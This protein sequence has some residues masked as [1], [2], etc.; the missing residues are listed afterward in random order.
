MGIFA[1]ILETAGSQTIFATDTVVSLFTGKSDPIVVS[2]AAASHFGIVP[3]VPSYPGVLA[4][5]SRFASTGQPLNFTVTALDPYGNVAP[6]YAGT[7][8]FTSSDSGATLPAAS[9][10]TG[11]I[12]VFT[13]TPATPGTQTLSVIDTGTVISGISSPIPVRGLVV[14]S[15][16]PTPSGF[17][18]TFNKAFNRQMVN[19]YTSTT[20]PDDVMLATNST[21]VSIRGSVLFNSPTNPVSMTFV[22]TDL[23]TAVGTFNPANGLLAAGKYTLTL[24]SFGATGNGFQDALGGAL[25]G[26][27]SGVPG[28]NFIFTFSVAAPPVAVG[29]P[30]FARGPSNTDAMVL[31]TTIGNGNTF[32][33]IYTNPTATPT[34]GTATITFSTTAATLLGNI[35]TALSTTTNANGGLAEQVGVT[36]NIPNSAVV[37]TNDSLTLGANVLITFQNTLA[38]ASNHILSSTTPGVSIAA[39]TIN[40]ANT[41]ATN[42]I[43]IALSS[44]LNVTSGSFT[45]QYNPSLLNI[46]GVVSKIAG[47]TLSFSQNT[48]S[49]TAA[50][51][52]LSLSSPSPISTSS[53]A[54]TLGSL[55][56]TVPVSATGSYGAKQL[57][58]FGSMQLNGTAGP[59]PVI[60][61][62]G[63]QVV[64]YLGDV[65]GAGG[66]LTL[67][68]AI[69]VAEQASGLANTLTQTIPGF[70][71]YPNLDPV[72]IGDVTLQGS[73]TFADATIMSQELVAA[74][75]Q[76]PYAPVGL[77]IA[78]S[79]NATLSTTPLTVGASPAL[80][81][82][83]AQPA[84]SCGMTTAVLTFEPTGTAAGST[85]AMPLNSPPHLDPACALRVNPPP[86]TADAS[87][88]LSLSTAP[89]LDWDPE[90]SPFGADYLASLEAYFGRMG[91]KS[92]K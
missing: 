51:V 29:I 38:T 80:I 19:L 54:I 53:A 47:A 35:Q 49:S 42:G 40:A 78:I 43:P 33:L 59:I 46:T 2:A 82:T 11:G 48:I 16:T 83:T 14:T 28:G 73:I 9:T 89:A 30:D 61:Q 10:L 22:K 62:D 27:N 21:Q 34:T 84:G 15:F 6:T 88:K 63:L 1:G 69:D 71:A 55:L 92:R 81:A 50:T 70:A 67:R 26:N 64:A 91:K 72:I 36:N 86:A 79:P 44:G 8:Q 60:N 37:V 76:I 52:T 45:L 23:V 12:G 18:V 7:V 75:P 77:P 24:R 4:G 32:N 20:S 74:R 66:P 58:H 31:P 56:A 39:A 3:T 41:I 90:P 68:D 87:G 57:L 85:L 5:P 17:S 25:D 65:I 13:G